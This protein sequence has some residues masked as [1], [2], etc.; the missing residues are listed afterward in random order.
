M[1]TPQQH[2][3]TSVAKSRRPQQNKS[4]T[5]ASAVPVGRPPT[6]KAMADKLDI[7]DQIIF[8][9][10]RQGHRDEA[11]V[12]RLVNQGLTAYKPQSIT[13]RYARIKKKMQQSNEELLDA[14]LTDWHEGEVGETV[15]NT[16]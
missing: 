10:K 6:T 1:L 7:E 5:N 8:D 3:V 9:M 4:F 12:A 16:A 14:E 11:V 2:T 15:F 13:A